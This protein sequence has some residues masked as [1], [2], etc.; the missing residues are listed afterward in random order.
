MLDVDPRDQLLRRDAFGLRLE[1]DGR[2]VRVVRADVV[3]LMA[4]QFLKAHPN[5]GLHGL[6]D[7]PQMQGPV[8]V[9]QGAGDEDSAV[10]AVMRNYAMSGSGRGCRRREQDLR[11][12]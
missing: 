5:V 11:G 9:G 12:G 8:G 6:E 10:V 1:H 4:A 7:M 2:A 3:A